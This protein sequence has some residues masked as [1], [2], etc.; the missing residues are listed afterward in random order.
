MVSD[1]GSSQKTRDF[2]IQGSDLVEGELGTG[3]PVVIPRDTRTAS[4]DKAD[5]GGTVQMAGAI[6]STSD[7][8]FDIDIE[9]M[10][11]SDFTLLTQTFS[12][13]QGGI[14]SDHNVKIEQLFTKS[15]FVKI[16]ITDTSGQSVNFI[17]GSFN[18]HQ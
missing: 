6:I 10:N 1:M 16:T 5:V 11:E 12:S 3:G 18:F 15:D 13:S 9:W 14:S 2:D 8:A 4:D 7:R 17:Q